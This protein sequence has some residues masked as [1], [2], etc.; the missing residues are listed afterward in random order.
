MTETKEKLTVFLKIPSNVITTPAEVHKLADDLHKYVPDY[1][2]ILLDD[3]I[4]TYTTEQIL[5]TA[6]KII[7]FATPNENPDISNE[8]N[9]IS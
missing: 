4:E 2:F 6:K 3:R 7:E 1:R 8:D 5:N 9:T